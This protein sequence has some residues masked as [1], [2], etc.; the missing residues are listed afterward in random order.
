MARSWESR[1]QQ[2]SAVVPPPDDGTISSLLE[3]ALAAASDDLQWPVF[4]EALS[5]QLGASTMSLFL[6]DP[7]GQRSSIQFA[8][9]KD[10]SYVKAYN[11]H[12]ATVSPFFGDWSHERWREGVIELSGQ[13]CPDRVLLRTEYYNDW[14]RPQKIHHLARGVVAREGEA[15]WV[16]SFGRPRRSGSITGRELALFGAILPG[17]RGALRLRHHLL[18]ARSERDAAS[19]AFDALRIGVIFLDGRDSAIGINRRAQAILDA[20]DGLKLERGTLSAS[21]ST[22]TARLRRLIGQVRE[23]IHTGGGMVAINRPSGRE[24]LHAVVTP[25]PRNHFHSGPRV[26]TSV[27][28]VMEREQGSPIDQEVVRAQYGLTHAEAAVVE[29]LVRGLT[30]RQIAAERRASIHTV[31]TQMKTVL[32]KTGA[33]ARPSSFARS[34]TVRRSWSR[35]TLRCGK[36]SVRS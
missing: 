29:G 17:L 33:G 20:A 3:A 12:F 25:P 30:L 31:R 11:E 15:S 4:L 26:A 9:G 34:C 16:L 18:V 36:A 14:L 32:S 24:P 35:P 19:A 21:C 2:R 28:F 7:V 27:V 10:P 6:S 23:A 1:R 5:S 8:A 22:D 13:V